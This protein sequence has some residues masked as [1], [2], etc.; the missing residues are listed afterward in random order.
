MCRRESEVPL[1]FA[2]AG[3]LPRALL[4]YMESLSLTHVH[5]HKSLLESMESRT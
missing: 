1:P 3:I 4:M 2:V 5:A